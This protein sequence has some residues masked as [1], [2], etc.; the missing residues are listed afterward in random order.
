MAERVVLCGDVVRLEP[1][2]PEHIDGLVAAASEERSTYGLTLVPDDHDAMKRYVD[3]ALAEE[4]RGVA[5]PFVTR[6][7]AGD[8]VV[9]STRYLDIECWAGGDTPTVVEI[10]STWLAA[11]AQRTAANTEAKLLM[12]GHAFDTWGVERVTFKTD[13]RNERSRNAI[14]RLGAQFEGI[15]RA[16]MPAFDGG[17]RDSA[18]YSIVR[19]EWP[20]VRRGLAARLASVS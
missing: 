1:M 9:G 15:R 17:I 18:Y 13:A 5:L 3:H 7:V 19:V 16:H 6:L 4:Q 8:R 11:S 2:G 14:V 12:L 10:G 20:A